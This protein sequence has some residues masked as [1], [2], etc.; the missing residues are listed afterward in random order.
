LTVPLG[1]YHTG[2][3]EQMREAFAISLRGFR[4]ATRGA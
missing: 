1:H 3:Y 2:L 4:L